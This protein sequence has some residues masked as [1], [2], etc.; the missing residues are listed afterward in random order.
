MQGY[1]I[2]RGH[3]DNEDF[4]RFSRTYSGIVGLKKERNDDVT[5]DVVISLTSFKRFLLCIPVIF[6]YHEMLK[7]EKQTDPYEIFV[8][9]LKKSWNVS[10][11]PDEDVELTVTLSVFLINISKY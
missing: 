10:H 3:P 11:L 4:T 8:E 9:K 2:S 5:F 6:E 1:L 7:D